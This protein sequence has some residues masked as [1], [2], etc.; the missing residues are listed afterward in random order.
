M[1]NIE[2]IA[3]V[4]LRENIIDLL[5]NKSL[6][7]R[8]EASS[9]LIALAV[10]IKENHKGESCIPAPAGSG[11]YSASKYFNLSRSDDYLHEAEQLEK[12]DNGKHKFK[13]FLYRICAEIL[14][15][16]DFSKDH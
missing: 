2:L 6:I 1:K 12:L 4:K 7:S 13:I 10:Y 3:D 5:Q 9:T 16:I 8:E 15:K 14:R 11:A